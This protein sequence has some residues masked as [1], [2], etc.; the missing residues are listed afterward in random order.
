MNK[1]SQL[2]RAGKVLAVGVAMLMGLWGPLVQASAVR[3]PLQGRAE[4]RWSASESVQV[5][6]MPLL[7]ARFESDWA[8]ARLAEALVQEAPYFQVFTHLP[9]RLMLSGQTEQGHWLAQLT[10]HGDGSRGLM[11]LWQ[12]PSSSTTAMRSLV[13]NGLLDVSGLGAPLMHVRF[14]EHGQTVEQLVLPVSLG[15]EDLSQTLSARLTQSHWQ[16]AVEPGLPWGVQVWR[17][18]GRVFFWQY[19]KRPAGAAVFV[20]YTE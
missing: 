18:S 9:G 16:R 13:L 6:G 20:H 8:V 4:V 15:Q 1:Q 17:K 10:E 11:S 5:W 3:F 19:Y 7:H 14:D 2:S 12:V